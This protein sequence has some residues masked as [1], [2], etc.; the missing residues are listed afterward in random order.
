MGYEPSS[1]VPEGYHIAPGNIDTSKP[2]MGAFDKLGREVFASALVI[3][4]QYRGIG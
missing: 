3:Y 2:F 1:I 4:C